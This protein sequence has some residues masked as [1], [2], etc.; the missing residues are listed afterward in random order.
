MQLITIKA[1]VVID[2]YEDIDE[3]NEKI[4]KKLKEDFVL[5]KGNLDV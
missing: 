1:L 3:E 5:M 4:I 2:H